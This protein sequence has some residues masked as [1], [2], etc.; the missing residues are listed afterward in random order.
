MLVLDSPSEQ[1]RLRREI[2]AHQTGAGTVPYP[3]KLYM[4]TTNKG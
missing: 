2:L 1:E 4:E 3:L